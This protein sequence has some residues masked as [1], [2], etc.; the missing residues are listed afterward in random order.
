MAAKLE[1]RDWGGGNN[2][3]EENYNLLPVLRS[4]LIQ[5]LSSIL[6]PQQFRSFLQYCKPFTLHPFL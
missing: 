3:V 2:H 4:Y 5:D 1:R 6:C